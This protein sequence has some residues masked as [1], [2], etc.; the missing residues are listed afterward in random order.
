MSF[1]FESLSW[2]VEVEAEAERLIRRGVPPWDAVI[3]ARQ[4]ISEKRRREA[5][6]ATERAA[7]DQ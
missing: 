7:E 6:E 4:R 2:R 5:T 3:Q 1:E